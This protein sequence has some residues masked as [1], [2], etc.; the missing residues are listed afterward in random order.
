MWIFLVN[1]DDA[2][3]FFSFF[4]WNSLNV[5]TLFRDFLCC[6]RADRI[7]EKRET[8]WVFHGLLSNQSISG[9]WAVEE[10]KKEIQFHK[11]REREREKKWC[12][13]LLVALPPRSARSFRYIQLIKRVWPRY[14]AKAVNEFPPATKKKKKKKELKK[15]SNQ[16]PMQTRPPFR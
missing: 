13:S 14:E 7:R 12:R 1:I 11:Q 10:T 16:P 4:G 9:N 8:S 15:I 5:V 2:K 6:L 3:L